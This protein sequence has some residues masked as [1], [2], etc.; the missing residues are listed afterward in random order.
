MASEPLKAQPILLEY[1]NKTPDVQLSVIVQKLGSSREA[2]ENISNLGGRVTQDLHIIN[3]FTAQIPAQSIPK[4]AQLPSVRWVSLDAPVSKSDT[5]VEWDD[6]EPINKYVKSI[7]A[8]KVWDDYRGTG[9][10]VAI[11]DSGVN[12]SQDFLRPFSAQNRLVASVAFNSDA[13]KTVFD[14]DG[15]GTHLAGVVAGSGRFTSSDDEDAYV[16]VAPDAN[17]I[18]VKVAN[19]DGSIQ[20]SSLIA[21]LQWILENKQRYNIR[22]VN[23]SLNSTVP[24]SYNVNPLCAAVEVLWF[25]GIVVVVSAGNYGSSNLH[26]PAND[27]FVITVGAVDDKGTTDPLDDIMPGYSAYGMTVDGFFKPE[28]VA[29]GKNIVSVA[30]PGG[31]LARNH[32]AHLVDANS[33][34]RMSGTSTSA[35][36]VSGAVALLMQAEPNL[37]PDQVKFRLMSTAKPFD[38]KLKT[39]AGY[40]NV[41]RAIKSKSTLGLANKGITPSRLISGAQ[42]APIGSSVS[43]TSVSWTSVSWT[44]VSWTSV[45]WTSTYWGN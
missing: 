17:I 12:P 3:S 4:I 45:S 27:P 28:I 11:L 10:G 1:A 9:V 43:W 31:R 44:S 25:N 36:M 42:P 33:Y 37:S 26:P 39:G 2:E 35:P 22:V 21:G 30:A 16:G 14:G 20:G 19:D 13:N 38:N 40:L 18:N 32:P 15:H 34:F 8:D 24:E 29:P 5:Q 23:I 7:R 6:I 41:E